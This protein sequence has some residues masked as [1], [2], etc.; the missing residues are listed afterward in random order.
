MV[1]RLEELHSV[2]EEG[3]RIRGCESEKLRRW[4]RRLELERLRRGKDQKLGWSENKRVRRSEGEKLRKWEGEIAILDFEFGILDWSEK[5]L[6][7]ELITN[8][9]LAWYNSL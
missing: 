4:R 8:L 5:T 1:R 6:T 3:K 9:M 7:E 2:K